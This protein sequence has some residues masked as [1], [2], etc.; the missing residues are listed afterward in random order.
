LQEYRIKRDFSLTTE[1]EDDS[2]EPENLPPE[3]DGSYVVQEHHARTLHWDFRLE[4]DG[5]LKNW[6]VPKGPPEEKGERR[7]AIEVEDHPLEYGK[8]EGTI[9][10]GNYGAGEVIIWDRGYYTLLKNEA[11]KIKVILSGE[12][13]QGAYML[14]KRGQKENHW[15]M[16]KYR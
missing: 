4:M 3:A 12:R 14:L 11:D 1:P 5:V 7:L 15:L 10:E 6:A 16:I 8:F 2:P 13:L 9:P